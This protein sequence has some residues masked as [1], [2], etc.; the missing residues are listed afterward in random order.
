MLFHRHLFLY[1]LAPLDP[2]FA[3]T[4]APRFVV[5]WD[6]AAGEPLRDPKAFP[7]TDV[8]SLTTGLTDELIAL[9]A[10]V[11]A[12][13]TTPAT[14]C[15]AEVVP[16]TSGLTTELKAPR[17]PPE[18]RF[19]GSKYIRGSRYRIRECIDGI[20]GH[21][22]WIRRCTSVRRPRK[23]YLQLLRRFLLPSFPRY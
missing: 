2:T 14:F 3:P 22:N 20:V 11:R 16:L 4:F 5:P 13:P 17:S 7:T 10:A 15:A 6:P 9:P 1:R 19:S 23:D 21:R 12:Q 18:V 8:I